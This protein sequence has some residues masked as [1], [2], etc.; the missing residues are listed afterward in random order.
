MSIAVNIQSFIKNK[1]SEFDISRKQ[2]IQESGIS[3]S[4]V[5]GLLNAMRVNPTLKC[6]IKIANYFNCTIDEVL[7]RKYYSLPLDIDKTMAYNDIVNNIYDY[8]RCRLETQKI[9]ANKL[10]QLCGIGENTILKSLKEHEI[11]GNLGTKS[12]VAIA[13]Y[14]DVSIDDMAKRLIHKKDK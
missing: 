12:L 4:V 6:L 3:A 9:T 2:F 10:S 14:F 5:S 8:I 7:G 13:D 11:K 1:L